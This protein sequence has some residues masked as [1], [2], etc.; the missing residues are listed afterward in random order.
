MTAAFV[1]DGS[2]T[3][4]WCFADEATPPSHRIQERLEHQG[5]VVPSHWPLEV[6]NVLALAEKHRRITPAKSGQ[7]LSLLEMLD[8]EVDGETSER[9][10][11]H[12]L[13]LCRRHGLTSYDAA[14]L[15][16]AI[17]RGIPLA[18]LDVDLL[19]GA[20]SLGIEVLGR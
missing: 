16:L 1:I 2:M 15:E 20:R 8:I 12:V 9:V 11:S 5:A 14:Y 13:P 18:S 4:A 19:R 6:A 10:F 17:R 3:M 7:F